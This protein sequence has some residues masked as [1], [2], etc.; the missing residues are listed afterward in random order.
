MYISVL[1]HLL[2]I[3]VIIRCEILVLYIYGLGYCRCLYS[4]VAFGFGSFRFLGWI[5][6]RFRFARFVLLTVRFE[7]ENLSLFCIAFS[8]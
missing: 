4:K 2:F 5:L 8:I 1:F 6:T 7:S 3:G